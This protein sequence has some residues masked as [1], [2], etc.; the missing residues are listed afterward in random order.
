[1]KHV[2]SGEEFYLLFKVE[3]MKHKHLRLTNHTERKF[4]VTSH[5]LRLPFIQLGCFVNHKK[6]TITVVFAVSYSHFSFYLLLAIFPWNYWHTF[7]TVFGRRIRPYLSSLCM[8]RSNDR[9]HGHCN[10]SSRAV[11]EGPEGSCHVQLSTA[12]SRSLLWDPTAQPPI[13][14]PLLTSYF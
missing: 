2:T 5:S 8:M 10:V 1:M 7:W 11:S 9:K 6:K 12:L 3:K 14:T 4:K 13:C